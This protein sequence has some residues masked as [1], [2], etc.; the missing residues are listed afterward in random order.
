MSITY[1]P[2]PGTVAWRALAHLGTMP[3]GTEMMTSALAEAI[4]LAA[5]NLSPNLEPA[6]A[7]GRIFRRQ[8]DNHVRS[9]FFWSLTDN[10]RRPQ[11][12]LR[13]PLLNGEAHDAGEAPAQAPNPEGAAA[14]AS[15][16]ATAEETTH[17]GAGRVCA[18][19]P[20]AR[21]GDDATLD[22]GQ[23]PPRMGLRIALWSDGTLQVQRDGAELALLSAHEV[24]QLMGYIHELRVMLE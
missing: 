4:G 8:R 13:K 19:A 20:P 11:L 7:A 5:N 23:P 9:P 2:R 6:L 22:G 24:E 15:G 10:G 12:D 3:P 16:P 21:A 17:R 1:E 14:A 18:A